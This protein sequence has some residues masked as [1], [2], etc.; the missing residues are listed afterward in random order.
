MDITQIWTSIIIPLVIG[1]IFLFGKAVYD[2]YSLKKETRDKNIYN[3]KITKIDNKLRLFFYP[4][5]LK[6]LCIYQLNYNIPE[7]ADCN[8]ELVSDSSGSEFEFEFETDENKSKYRKKRRCLG[9]VFNSK[10]E[11]C[12]RLIPKNGNELCKS[13]KN[14]LAK[15]KDNCEIAGSRLVP[16]NQHQH[17]NQ[18]QNHTLDNLRLNEVHINVPIMKNV[19][20]DNDI[21]GLG[22][23]NVADLEFISSDIDGDTVEILTTNLSKYF[24]EAVGIIENNIS[25]ASPSNKFGRELVY[26]L[27]Y[28]KIREIIHEGSVNQKYKVE[29]FG[30]R[31]NLNRLLSHI[32]FFVFNL[33]DEYNYL[34]EHG[35]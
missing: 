24:D 4:L 9:V 21:T 31:N 28:T 25:V 11:T 18:H 15:N 35:P 16:A 20:N 29:Q 22:I 10:Y 13:C 8:S 6:L 27:K 14:I 34:I 7:H 17:Q 23:G 1:P 19:G 33:Q 30:T 2:R 5:Y 32:E 12:N 26:F 3:D